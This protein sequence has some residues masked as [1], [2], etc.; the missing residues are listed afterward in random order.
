M[1]YTDPSTGETVPDSDDENEHVGLGAGDGPTR[2][3]AYILV[4]EFFLVL[5]LALDF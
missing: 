3:M 1:F 2:S 5:F 4:R